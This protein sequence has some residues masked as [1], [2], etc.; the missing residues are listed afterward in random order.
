M[1]SGGCPRGSGRDGQESPERSMGCKDRQVE[2]CRN[3]RA[4]GGDADQVDGLG[5]ER[6]VG[7][8]SWVGEGRFTV[9][10]A[11]GKIQ[12]PESPPKAA[13][14][15]ST[16]TSIRYGSCESTSQTRTMCSTTFSRDLV[17][18]TRCPFHVRAGG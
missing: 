2:D 12:S 5:Q 10:D 6:V 4:Y 9:N 11:S 18:W 14:I 16:S 1:R 7:L 15:R 3:R 8:V 17:G 13:T